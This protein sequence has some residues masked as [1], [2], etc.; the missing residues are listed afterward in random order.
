MSSITAQQAKLDLELVPKEKR[1]AIRKCNERLNSRKI[2]REPTFQVVLDA[3]ALTTSYSAFLITTDFL[4][5]DVFKSCPCVQ[6]QDFDIL[7]TNDDIVSFL[8]ELG[9]T[10]EINSLN[11]VVVDHMHQPWRTFAALINK[12]LSGKT[13]SY[14]KL[15]T[16]PVSNEA[17][18]R[19]LKRVKRP[20]K[21]STETPTRVVVIR[22]TPEMPLS[23]KKE[24]MTVEKRKGIDLLSELKKNHQKVKLNL[25]EM[26]KMITTM[27]KTQVVKTM[28]KRMTVM[29]KK[30]TQRMNTNKDDEEDVK[31]E[32]VKTASN[33]SDDKV[34]G[35]E[36]EEMDYSTS[37]LY[38]D[39]DIRLNE[40]VDTDKRFVQEED[41]NAKNEVPVTSSSHSSDLAAK[42]LNFLDIPHKNAKIISPLDVHVRHEVPNQQTPTLLIVPISVITDSSPLFSTIILKSLP[43]FTP[44]PKQ[45]TC[46]PPPTT[47]AINPVSTLLDFAPVFQ[48]YNRVTT[49]EKEV[50]E[51]KEV[52]PK[53]VSNF[54]PLVI[55]SMVTE[56]LKKAILAKES[57]QPQSS[58]EA[59]ATLTE[60]KLKKILIDK[61]DKSESY[62]AAPEHR[63]YYEGL[64]KSYYLDKNF[65]S[66]YGKVYSLKR[67]RKTKIKMK[68]LLLEF[69]VADSD[70]PHDQ[71]EN[72]GNDDEVP[73][74]KN[75]LTNLS[76][77]DVSEFSI[78]L[79]MFT[80]SLVIQKRVVDLQLGVESYQKKINVTKPKTTKSEIR[81]RD[82]Y[83]PYQDPQG[84]IYINDNGRNR[85]MRS[86]ELYKFS[87]R[88]LT[89]L[90]TS[91]DDIK[92]N[93]RME[94]L[95]KRRWSTLENKRA[96]IMIK[97]IDKQLKER[98]M[99][100]S[101]EK[102][103][104]GRDNGTD[105][106]LL[107]RT[108]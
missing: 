31:D 19:K 98:R 15:T 33:E 21:K 8:K 79:R 13:T 68:T 106:R 16:V 24:K 103:I 63:E 5:V 99:M 42:F 89:R 2:Q 105:L 91:Q 73:K 17:P 3:L 22:E 40:P 12:S 25:E 45:S 48:F 52:L 83:T 1:L 69:K 74:E 30:H 82:P 23:K 85:L 70:M 76:G 9:H 64:K 49:L 41:T 94:Y 58:Y 101:L 72:S 60:F 67:S 32:F 11:D 100:R 102:F 47:K 86:D 57:S 35:D 84:F 62:L 10:R 28:I 53:E 27:N 7:H 78:A 80:R 87:D 92:N 108:I 20:A 90:R 14:P 26:M 51:L 6:G 55:Q 29:M 46:I 95:Q 37:Q 38:D 18:T 56:S 65:F 44:P 97:A 93:I 75:R 107:Q 71:E 81:K 43:S 39:V 96:N 50:V 4:K 66:T 88:T 34:E 77:D 36:D 59:N 104:G 54:S 61:M